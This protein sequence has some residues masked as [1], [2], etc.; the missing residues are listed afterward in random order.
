[1][2]K[3]FISVALFCVFITTSSVIAQ[4]NQ[5]D[6][7][8]FDG[9]YIFYERDS[10]NI[11][12]AIEDSAFSF[13]IKMDQKTVFNGFQKD[14]FKT[15]FVPQSFIDE[16]YEFA[17][18]KK[19][20]VISDVHGQYD[21]FRTLLLSSGVIDA[22]NNWAWGKG[23]LVILGDT[24]DKGEM[25][26][27]C[28]WLI[29]N[30]EEQ[31]R[32][33]GG[34]V[35]FIL[36]NHEVKAL[37]G[38]LKYVTPNYFKLAEVLS[39]PIPDLYKMN[40]F[41][42]RWLRSKNVIIKIDDLLFVHGGIHPEIVTEDYTITKINRIMRENI[43]LSLDEIKK[44][45]TLSFLFRKNGPIRYRGFFQPDTLA[46][47]SNNQITKILNYFDVEKIVV[48]HTSGEHIYTSHNNRVICVD[49]RIMYGLGSE[50]L[51]IK[52]NKY[53]VI[54]KEGNKRKLF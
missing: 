48:G 17:K 3:L 45:S 33:A 31:A 53:F 51:L 21:I 29:Y 9:P 30:L 4:D 49:G 22:N 14:S 18:R 44:D 27:E 13:N 50:V 16:Q 28:L 20:L 42:G 32:E 24:F 37:R 25:V 39:I 19:I 12:Y 47:V 41:W 52:K 2:N 11:M 26:H 34:F 15:Y 38:D 5:K 1:M 23:H 43:D 54:D 6:E 36:G 40:T 46:E 10:L 7:L 35:H 8:F